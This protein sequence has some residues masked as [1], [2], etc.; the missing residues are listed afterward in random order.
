MSASAPDFT[1]VTNGPELRVTP[2]SRAAWLW[3]R[4]HLGYELPLWGRPV[5]LHAN[6]AIEI[7]AALAAAGLKIAEVRAA[8][9]PAPDRPGVGREV[10]DAA[11]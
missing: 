11:D 7:R 4:Q 1:L 5:L 2:Q 3:A 10:P 6:R 9:A 8:P